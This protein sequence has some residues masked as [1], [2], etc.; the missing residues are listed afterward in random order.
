MDILETIRGILQNSPVLVDRIAWDGWRAD[1]AVMAE[2]TQ[3]AR[4]YADGDHELELTEEMRKMLRLPP[5]AEGAPF[6][7]N[8]CET[9]I[10]TPVD[11]LNVVK[12]EA[13]TEAA[14]AWCQDILDLNRFDGLQLDV[15][16][17]TIGDGNT[18]VLVEWDKVGGE[19]RLTH[20]PAFDGS[21]G[22]LVV[23]G[24]D[25]RKPAA[26]IKVWHEN[27]TEGDKLTSTTRI[28]IYF[29]DRVQKYLLKNNAL[30]KYQ[31]L[32]EAWPAPWTN[33]LGKPIGLPVIHFRNNG[34]KH[35]AFGV[36]ILDNVIPL[37]DSLNRLLMSLTMGA[38]LEAF[39]IRWSIGVK[40]PAKVTPGMFVF[41]GPD[42][43]TMGSAV[44]TKEQTDWFNS[45]K[46][47][48]FEQG[49][50]SQYLSAADFL[51]DQIYTVTRI[52]NNK[53]VGANVSGEALRQHET[54]LLGILKRCQIGFGNAWEDVLKL[55]HAVQTAFGTAPAE[56]KRVKC[57]WTPAE[58]RNEAQETD[59]IIK[60]ADYL[61]EETIIEELAAVRG[62]DT[63][64]VQDILQRRRNQKEARIAS[65]SGITGAGGFAPDTEDEQDL[66]TEIPAFEGV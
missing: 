20:E 63:T 18:F 47:G 12:F 46:F 66:L 44:P 31:P 36:S 19:V 10:A 16:E 17:S 65:Y 32:D 3:K 40:P 53:R 2:K 7:L 62:W 55:A 24:A 58:L 21:E 6:A 15:H 23:Y 30:T 54:G 35:H 33:A 8:H 50:L 64:K 13:D 48:N 51:I 25:K 38:E 4:A 29:P 5:E 1:Q 49:D 34:K 26:A 27:V 37:Q 59:S 11:R 43:E 45:I 56:M 9:I 28:N 22:M 60:I 57:V 39:K 42:P 52:P 41:V 14:S 61:D